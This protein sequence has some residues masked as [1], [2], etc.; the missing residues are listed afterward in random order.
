M[1]GYSDLVGYSLKNKVVT[2]TGAS[3][4][5]GLA[6]ARAFA[7][8]GARLAIAARSGDKLEALAKELRSTGTEV[9]CRTMDVTDELSVTRYFEALFGLWGFTD[10]LVN[11][12]GIGLFAPVAE[13]SV[14]LLDK[15]VQV[16]VY[17]ALR[18]IRAVLP[19][20]RARARGQIINISSTAGKRSFPYYG[21]YCAT[22]SAL[23]ALTD[24]LRVE[25]KDEGIDVLLVCPGFVET[26]FQESS[27]SSRKQQ[28]DLPM[29]GWS[30][31]E[32]A[33]EIVKS[34][35][36][37]TREVVLSASARALVAAEM[38]APG[39]IDSALNQLQ[40]RFVSK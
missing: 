17:G 16:N 27:L 9:F 22:K 18:C 35:K 23:N 32:V 11:N 28:P 7:A 26:P 31:D 13:L 12:A 14:D 21:G 4:G 3:S 15:A 38:V 6:A 37:K 24:A 40:R 33:D 1:I 25:V 20:M 10:V 36:K 2:V 5:I 30:A 19:V 34:S 29:R 39:L 8:E